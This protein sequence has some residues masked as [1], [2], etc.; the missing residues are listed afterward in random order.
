MKRTLISLAVLTLLSGC[1]SFKLG[2]MVYIPH[3]EHGEV[4][5]GPAAK[6]LAPIN[7]AGAA[8]SE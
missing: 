4:R 6:P 5:V 8:V 3:G 1:A 2:T 7:A